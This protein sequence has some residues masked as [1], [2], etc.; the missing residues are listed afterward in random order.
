MNKATRPRVLGGLTVR[1]ATGCG[2]MYIQLNWHQGKLFEVFATL[3]RSGACAMCYSE[4]LTRSVTTGLRCGVT[5]AEYVDQLRG[6]RCPS[7]IAFPKDQSSLSCPDT[8]ARALIEYGSLTVD[9]VVKLML[10]QNTSSAVSEEDEEKAA[11]A[12]IEEM[13]FE[14]DKQGL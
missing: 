3:G 8:I 9:N 14:R 7:P 5:V 2:N 12:K 1:M 10:E 13:R 4:A 6:I 11:I